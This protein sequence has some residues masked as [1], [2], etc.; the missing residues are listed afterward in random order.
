MIYNLSINNIYK[1]KIYL[2]SKMTIDLYK[3]TR[4]DLDKIHFLYKLIEGNNLLR[5]YLY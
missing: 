2:L 1:Y 3:I 5:I 4:I